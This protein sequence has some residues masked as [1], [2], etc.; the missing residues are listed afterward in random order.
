[1]TER[2]AAVQVLAL[3]FDHVGDCNRYGNCVEHPY[4]ERPTV[5]ELEL[6]SQ[7]MPEQANSLRYVPHDVIARDENSKSSPESGYHS[8]RT[9]SN[10][11]RAAVGEAV[12]QPHRGHSER[13]PEILDSAI[14]TFDRGRV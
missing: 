1:M 8:L 12:H 5:K 6:Y 11:L 7:R 9:K 3:S 2:D 13:V 14:S 10:D 4:F